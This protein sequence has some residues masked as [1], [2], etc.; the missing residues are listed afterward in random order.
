MEIDDILF[1]GILRIS[2]YPAYPFTGNVI[3]DLIT[4]FVLP[5]ILIFTIVYFGTESIIPKLGA[6]KG[7]RIL[8]S[9][10]VYLYI[11]TQG[12]FGIIARGIHFYLIF[13]LILAGIMFL[14]SHIRT[15]SIAPKQQPSDV[16]HELDHMDPAALE[17]AIKLQENIV[18][19]YEKEYEM[20]PDKGRV[21]P[22]LMQA[23]QKLLELCTALNAR[24]PNRRLEMTIKRLKYQLKGY[25]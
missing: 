1:R 19:Q 11:I 2:D 3:S 10:V 17:E 14:L 24:N 23:R 13:F 20:L 9:V 18:K 4:F 16:S 25:R 12:M 15:R 7:F 21:L 8:F 6:H 22:A 5:T